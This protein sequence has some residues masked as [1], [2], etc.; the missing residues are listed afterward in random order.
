MMGKKE[1]DG[2]YYLRGYVRSSPIQ[3]NVYIEFM[4]DSSQRFTTISKPDA[5]KNEVKLEPLEIAEGKFEVRNEKIKAYVI[6]NCT[7]YIPNED[8][9][10]NYE[11]MLPRVYVPFSKI[12]VGS[13]E[14]NPSRLGL[15]F[16]EYCLIK[17]QTLD[18]DR[19]QCIILEKNP[20][21]N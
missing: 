21:T 3:R 10:S 20:S 16:L 7:I 1:I 13:L 6:P 5:E 12:S 19:D 18:L 2:R 15:D 11:I 14:A 8:G 9:R 17:F 4:I